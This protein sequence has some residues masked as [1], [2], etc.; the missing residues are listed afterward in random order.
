[1][2]RNVTDSTNSSSAE[3]LSIFEI[4]QNETIQNSKNSEPPIRVL[5]PF[6]MRISLYFICIAGI[7]LNLAIFCKRKFKLWVFIQ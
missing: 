3:L 2:N 6:A 1:M 7:I 5:S 4:I